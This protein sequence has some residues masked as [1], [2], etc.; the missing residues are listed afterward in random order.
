MI[1]DDIHV[2]IVIEI[3]ECAARA[4]CGSK[5][6]IPGRADTSS[7]RPLRRFL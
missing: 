5:N 3:A 7:K 2:S 4:S 1:D 6:A